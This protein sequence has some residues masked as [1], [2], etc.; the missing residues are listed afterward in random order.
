MSVKDLP[1]NLLMDLSAE[2]QQDVSG[3]FGFVGGLGYRPWG[4]GAG[5]GFGGYRGWV[6]GA[7][8]GFGGFGVPRFAGWGF[9]LGRRFF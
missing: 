6:F 4:Y 3:G 8:R 1:S 5:P 7:G 2:E 9:G